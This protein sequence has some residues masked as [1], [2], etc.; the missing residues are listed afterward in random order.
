MALSF[1]FNIAPTDQSVNCSFDDSYVCGW[2]IHIYGSEATWAY[3]NGEDIE[4]RMST[5]LPDFD[6]TRMYLSCVP[7]N[8]DQNGF[9][10]L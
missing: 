3:R 10:K 5:D 7:I 1:T 4:A 2:L 6:N 8:S 9:I